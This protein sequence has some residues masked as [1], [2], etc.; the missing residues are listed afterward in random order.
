MESST[1]IKEIDTS[2]GGMRFRIEAAKAR[3]MSEVLDACP[4]VST[5]RLLDVDEASG[6]LVFERMSDFRPLTPGMPLAR[7]EE[8]GALLALV[9]EKLVLPEELSFVHSE[10]KVTGPLVYLHGDFQPGNLAIVEEQL[11][12][13]DWGIRPW[14]DEL[15]TQGSPVVDLASFLTP[16]LVPKWWDFRFPAPGLGAFLASYL[17]ASRQQER[18]TFSFS[19]LEKAMQ[20]HYPKY[21]RAIAARSQPARSVYFL[22]NL[23]NT[24]RLNRS[25]QAR[26]NNG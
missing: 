24:W 22:K 11:V 16:W 25:L 23:I 17:T 12:V 6:R 2:D 26:I 19:D 10:D 13:F 8:I 21:R 20:R 5:P 7:F 18:E 14:G 4:G 3:C 15:Y 9:H 1:F